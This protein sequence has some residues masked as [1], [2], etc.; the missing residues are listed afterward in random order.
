MLLGISPS[1]TGPA[2]KKLHTREIKDASGRKVY[3]P[4]T[5]NSVIALR[6]GALR[7][8]AY[9][10][11]TD[12]IKYIEG[13]ERRRQVPYLFA[14]PSLR[15]KDLIGAGNN[16][17]NELLAASSADIIITTFM[18]AAEADKLQGKTGKPVFVLD[19]G[20]LKENSEGFYMSLDLLGQVFYRKK[21]AEELKAFFRANLD[22]L[23]LR[24]KNIDKLKV[25]VGGVAY[26]GAHGISS[27]EPG[28]PPFKMLSLDNVASSLGEVMS[29]P[30]ANQENAF[31]DTEQLIVWDPDYIFLDAAGREIWYNEVDNELLK[32]TITAFKN[33]R[34]YTV[35]PYNWYTTNYE[36]VLCNAW[37]IGKT[38]DPL[39]FEHIDIEDKCREIYT[40]F[41]GSD[42]YDEMAALYDPFT[43]VLNE[44]M[45]E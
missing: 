5:I 4:D 17:D 27:T 34:L 11:L 23:K 25:Y 43:P 29:S 31:I 15:Q 16:Y 35:L 42:V 8:I 22:E 6:A 14:N 28:Y 44:R 13:N 36:N 20:D 33:E 3:I 37:F 19:Y 26:R 38:L 21:R 10:G 18:T 1:C 39:A 24:A 7:L 9:M 45:E 30:V 12:R 41:L 32:E 40:F 2:G